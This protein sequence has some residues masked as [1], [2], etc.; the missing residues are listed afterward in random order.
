MFANF[1]KFLM[2]TITKGFYNNLVIK[3]LMLQ[4]WFKPE[5]VFA[6]P[7]I[8]KAFNNSQ[9]IDVTQNDKKFAD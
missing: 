3:I 8:N 9:W 5:D 4:R 2:T 6:S 7:D 1:N